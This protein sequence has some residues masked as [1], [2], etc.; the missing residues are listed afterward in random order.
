[1]EQKINLLHIVME[2]DE[3]EQGRV[4]QNSSQEYSLEEVCRGNKQVTLASS[5]MSGSILSTH[6]KHWGTPSLS[7][8]VLGN[9]SLCFEKLRFVMFLKVCEAIRVLEQSKSQLRGYIDQLLALVLD[10]DPSLLEGLP[11]IQQNNGMSP[12]LLRVASLP[13]VKY[14]ELSLPGMR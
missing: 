9:T 7:C 8:L 2:E 14:G 11:R 4:S 10:R 5:A 13:E 12:D 6:A 1:M 3:A